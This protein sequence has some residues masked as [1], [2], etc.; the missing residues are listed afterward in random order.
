[1]TNGE[2]KVIDFPI[3]MRTM[4]LDSRATLY[5]RVNTKASYSLWGLLQFQLIL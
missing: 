3:E 5:M 4:C 1:M 2:E